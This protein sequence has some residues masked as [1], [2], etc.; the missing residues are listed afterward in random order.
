MWENE[1]LGGPDYL[2]NRIQLSCPHV[3]FML[4]VNPYC[5]HRKFNCDAESPQQQAH[6]N[7]G[8]KPT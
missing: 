5:H 4:A 7:M 2:M 1:V 3:Q 6:I 8:L